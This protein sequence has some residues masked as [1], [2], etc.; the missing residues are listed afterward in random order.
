MPK[1]KRF[2]YVSSYGNWQNTDSFFSKDY[3]PDEILYEK[4]KKIED[5]QNKIVKSIL[6]NTQYLCANEKN[7][8]KCQITTPVKRGNCIL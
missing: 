5:S 1:T 2:I 4:K 7:N 6:R 8:I 3:T